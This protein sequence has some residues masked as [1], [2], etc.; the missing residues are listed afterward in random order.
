M[1]EEWDLV[2]DINNAKLEVTKI[3][4]EGTLE[5]GV[6]IIIQLLEYLHVLFL[7]VVS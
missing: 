6:I 7:K 3:A 4:E 1:T 5:F 2:L